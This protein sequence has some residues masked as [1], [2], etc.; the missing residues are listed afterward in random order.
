MAL[1]LPELI[2][3][4]VVALLIFGPKKLP[5]MGAQIGR[6][7]NAFKKGMSE[8]SRSTLDDPL[9]SDSFLA[10]H[11]EITA[12]EARRLELE[13]RER[14]IKVK[15]AEAALRAAQEK[16]IS[17]Y[18]FETTVEE[19]YIESDVVVDADSMGSEQRDDVS[20]EADEAGAVVSKTVAATDHVASKK[21]DSTPVNAHEVP[22][23][24][25]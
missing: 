3:I 8:F 16:G 12:L 2:V 6:S 7:I 24:E 20:V 13:I 21:E 1:R 23:S 9:D 19:E 18:S 22:V 14:E 5:E 15:T 11:N 17:P 25:K 4:F 10:R